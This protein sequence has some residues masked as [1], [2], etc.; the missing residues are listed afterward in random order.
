MY[1]QAPACEIRHVSACVLATRADSGELTTLLQS[2][3][4]V[5][6]EVKAQLW[7][8]FKLYARDDQCVGRSQVDAMPLI[9][10]VAEQEQEAAKARGDL[11]EKQSR[12]E[13]LQGKLDNPDPAL[14]ASLSQKSDEILRNSLT[15]MQKMNTRLPDGGEKS[16]DY[17]TAVQFILKRREDQ[18]TKEKSQ[19]WREQVRHPFEDVQLLAV[20]ESDAH[21]LCPG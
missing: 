6:L 8:L 14:V 5:K 11:P 17:C 1:V 12:L 21:V 19:M 13:Q 16:Q 2:A 18:R 20:T 9:D 7:K 4:D 3:T 10:Q 15:T